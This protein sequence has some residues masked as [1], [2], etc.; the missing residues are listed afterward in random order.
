MIDLLTIT[1]PPLCE[2][3][4]SRIVWRNGLQTN[5]K[6]GVVFYDNKEI[7][8][9]KQQNGIYICVET[10]RRLKLIGSLQKYYNEI[11]G[12]ERNNYNAFSMSQAKKAIERLFFDKGINIE[13]ARIYSYE[14]GINLNVEKDCRAYMNKMKSIG[15]VGN[16]KPLYVNSQYKDERAESTLS[17][18]D[19]RKYFKV[20]DKI[21]EMR[22]RKKK[23]IPE[24]NILRIETV[25]RR[26][27]KCLVTDFFSP[28]NLKKMVEI[29]FR[30]WRTIQF[31][32]DIITPKGTGRARQH[33]CADIMRDGKEIVLI[34]AKDRHSNGSLSDWEYRNI[35]EFITRDWDEVKNEIRFI[36]SV[37]ELEFRELINVN[38]TILRHDEIIKC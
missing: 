11:S 36:K 32:Q 13:N 6:S 19:V 25:N 38:H 26:L 2:E 28:D 15:G 14:I 16:E 4:V 17:H 24:G 21:F 27:D 31:E 37:E 9:L 33:L 20:Y 34:K 30:D 35:R 7:K 1:T 22:D 29:F 3:D 12:N 23:I 8:N 10:N 18:R 5:S